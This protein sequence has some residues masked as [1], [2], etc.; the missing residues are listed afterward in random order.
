M[1]IERVTVSRYLA[2]K[3]SLIESDG[4]NDGW[5][6]EID[7]GPFSREFPRLREVHSIVRGLEFLN[8]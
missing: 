8:R 1:Q 5:P 2:F 6:V 3:E 4:L 7:F